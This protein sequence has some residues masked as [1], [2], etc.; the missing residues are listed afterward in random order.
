MYVLKR[1]CGRMQDPAGSQSRFRMQEVVN[2]H[3][4]CMEY[5]LDEDSKAGIYE[6][7]EL[8][9][10][11][12]SMLSTLMYVCRPPRSSSLAA[13]HL[14]CSVLEAPPMLHAVRAGMQIMRR[15]TVSGGV[16][17]GAK[18][19][20]FT[21][22][23]Q[24]CSEPPSPGHRESG[25]AKTSGMSFLCGVLQQQVLTFVGSTTQGHI[26]SFVPAG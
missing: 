24:G 20:S 7:M 14:Q 6:L 4:L 19:H 13:S 15:A 11:E 16:K 22:V 5:I 8:A 3:T 12:L 21:S 26:A 2:Q 17:A 10:A 1:V 25:Q 23:A 9:A 18:R